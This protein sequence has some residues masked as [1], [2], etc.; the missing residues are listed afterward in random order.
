M[1]E[2]YANPIAE[3]DP[4][5]LRADV[6]YCPG[7]AMSRDPWHYRRSESGKYPLLSVDVAVTDAASVDLYQNISG[8]QAGYC[9]VSER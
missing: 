5:Y 4:G 6:N 8:A 7:A 9:H 1:N 3:R 2:R